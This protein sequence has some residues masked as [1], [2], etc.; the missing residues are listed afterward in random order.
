MLALRNV[1]WTPPHASVL[2]IRAQ[3]FTNLTI[4]GHTGFTVLYMGFVLGYWTLGEPSQLP[5]LAGARLL[6]WLVADVLLPVSD[7]RLI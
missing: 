7:W 1:S 3:V 2:V 4:G 6:T 5:S